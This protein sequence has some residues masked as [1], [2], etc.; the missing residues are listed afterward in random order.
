[1]PLS[2]KQLLDLYTQAEANLVKFHADQAAIE[3]ERLTLNPT[4]SE[5]THWNMEDQNVKLKFYR[6]EW[7]VTYYEGEMLFYYGVRVGS[8]KLQED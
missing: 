2:E 7:E 4:N 3:A 1:M 6:L 8:K 5:R